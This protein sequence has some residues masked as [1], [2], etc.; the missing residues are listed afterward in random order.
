MLMQ[1]TYDKFHRK[2]PLRAAGALKVY[3]QHKNG[4]KI[5]HQGE[6]RW[7]KW[8]QDVRREKFKDLTQTTGCNTTVFEVYCNASYPVGQVQYERLLTVGVLTDM[9]HNY[10]RGLGM[11]DLEMGCLTSHLK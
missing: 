6:S 8:R 4:Q 2:R 9:Y 10:D 7:R 5:E 1:S 3:F 11:H